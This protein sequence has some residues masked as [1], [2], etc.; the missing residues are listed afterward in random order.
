MK[1]PEEVAK[2]GSRPSAIMIVTGQVFYAMVALHGD[3]SYRSGKDHGY[4]FSIKE[5]LNY[6]RFATLADNLRVRFKPLVYFILAVHQKLNPAIPKLARVMMES[7]ALKVVAI[8]YHQLCARF[9][10]YNT[11][12]VNDQK[13][14]KISNDRK[15]HVPTVTD[16]LGKL[17]VPRHSFPLAMTCGMRNFRIPQIGTV[18][19]PVLPI[20]VHSKELRPSVHIKHFRLPWPA[21]KMRLKLPIRKPSGCPGHSLRPHL[22]KNEVQQKLIVQL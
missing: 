2:D 5:V 6:I 1:I 16:Q 7:Q 21:A 4:H 17:T 13:N 15:K 3:S 11:K 18:T 8:N 22:S 12:L 10:Q 14:Q 19:P 9:A 20:A